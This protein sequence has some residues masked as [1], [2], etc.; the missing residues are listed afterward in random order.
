MTDLVTTDHYVEQAEAASVYETVDSADDLFASAEEI[1]QLAAQGDLDQTAYIEHSEG[2]DNSWRYHRIVKFKEEERINWEMK[3]SK[4][5]IDEGFRGFELNPNDPNQNV[6][7]V[8]GIPIEFGFT[9]SWSKSNPKKEGSQYT[10]CTTNELIEHL[11]GKDKTTKEQYPIKMPFP[12]MHFS[13]AK[14]N[15]LHQFWT[16]NAHLDPYATRTTFQKDG[17]EWVRVEERRSCLECVKACEHFEGDDISADNTPR[18]RPTGRLLFVVFE[19][20]IKNVT[21]HNKDI[22]N[23]PIKIDWKPI[24][25]AGIL[26]YDNTPLT[27]PFVI[28]LMGLGSSQMKSIGKGPYDLPVY[29]PG[30]IA[31]NRPKDCILPDNN[32]KSAEDYFNWLNDPK[33]NDGRRA[34]GKNGKNLYPVMTELYIAKMTKVESNKKVAPV[35][36][37]VAVGPNAQFNGVSLKDY[38]FNAKLVLNHEAAVAQGNNGAG[39]GIPLLPTTPSNGNSGQA[40]PAAVVETP[41][42]KPI[43]VEASSEPANNLTKAAITAFTPPTFQ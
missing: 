23:N 38:V 27:T 26:G 20:G 3:L 12:R 8:R 25:E 36:R 7:A 30:D 41:A 2:Y 4:E 9:N 33:A 29:L 40:L 22:I 15:E 14:S 6:V 32:V 18:C 24:A 42:P 10:Y 17:E 5:Q 34:P 1:Q 43:T 31:P 13:K 19:V 37:P 39:G 11:P 35:F 21:E 16:K 28:N